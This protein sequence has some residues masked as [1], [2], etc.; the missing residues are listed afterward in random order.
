MRAVAFAARRLARYGFR[1]GLLLAVLGVGACARNKVQPVQ[2][3][4]APIIIRVPEARYVPIPDEMT[5]ACRWVADG[6]LQDVLVVARGR[7][8][9]LERYESQLRQIRAV[10][11]TPVPVSSDL[12]AK[13]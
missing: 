10:Q 2:P 6:A 7:R 11:G 3:V 13:P 8:Q 5:E 4:P 9:C 12:G 1:V